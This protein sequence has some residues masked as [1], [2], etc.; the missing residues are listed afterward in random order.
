MNLNPVI[1]A[2]PMY[3]TLMAVE[4]VYES[5]TRRRT[6]RLHDAV[7]NIS[8]GTLQQLTGTF[9]KLFKIGIY[10]IVY[11]KWALFHLEPNTLNFIILFVLWDLCYY[12]EHRMAHEISLFWGG[13]VVHHQSEDFNLSVAL[14]QT[15]TGFIWGLPFYLPLALMG[16]HPVHFVLAG[17]FNLLYQFWIHTE[18]I[19]KLPRWFE[20]VFNTPSHHRVHHGRDPKYIDKNYAGVLI[21]WDRLFGTFKEEEER[22]HYGITKP[23]RSWNPVYA[24]FAHYIDLARAVPKARSLGDALRILFKRPGW[25][26]DYLGGYLAPQPVDERS[27]RKYDVEA[28]REINLYVLVQFLA[29][30]AINS[31]Y[32][33]KSETFPFPFKVGFA[34]WIVWTTLMFGFLFEKKD[35]RLGALE[36]LRLL[37]M[38]LGAWW[39]VQI[40]L[41]V[42]Q[43]LRLSLAVFAGA[44]ALALLRIWK[45]LPSAE[46]VAPI[47][48]R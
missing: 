15:S 12:W 41:E 42:P 34:L 37:A 4:L 36:L 39:A 10:T 26:P 18:H 8:T 13:H 35:R 20:F 21:I 11:E 30:L 17:G 28:A 5:I 7:T 38:P 27:F 33:F 46:K 2:I 44:S 40:G 25:M 48:S 14:R 43:V 16:F 3:F 1:L 9:I 19:G 47:S 29:A 45:S 22:P 6:Y 24:N 31:L 23:L 32:F